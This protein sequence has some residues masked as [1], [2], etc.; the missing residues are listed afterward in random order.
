MIE[1]IALPFRP[2]FGTGGED[3]DFFRRMMQNGCRFVWCNEGV[4]YEVVPPQR[5]RRSYMLRRALQ[6]GQNERYL[7][8]LGS[9]AKSLAAVPCYALLAL[10]LF[11]VRHDAFMKCLIRLCDH[12]GKLLAAIGLKAAGEG[13]LGQ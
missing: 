9:I 11:L 3:Q 6:R 1:G 5:F 13:Y 10:P 8:S 12:A 7:L 4:V 2:E